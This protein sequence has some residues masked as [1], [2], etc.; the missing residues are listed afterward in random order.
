MKLHRRLYIFV[1]VVFASATL[2]AQ[3]P[4]QD[5]R[6]FKTVAAGAEYER[7][8]S[9]QKLWGFNRR[10]EWATPVRVPV[11]WLDSAYGRLEPY[12]VGG[13][14]E[15]KSLRLR[16]SNGKEYALRSI[17]KSRDE[18]IPPSLQKTFAEDIIRDGVSMSHPY[19]AFAIPHMLEKAG[20]CHTKP[21]LVY[22]PN[23]KA[24]D[25][26]DQKFGGDLYLLEQ[27]PE[28]DWS[29]ADH[30]GNFEEFDDTE[31]VI[32]SILKDHHHLADQ[33]T[34]AKA[35]LFDMLIADWDRHEG[36]WEW[37]KRQN[38][39]LS[40]YIPVPKDRDQAFY[41]HNGIIIDK[42]IPATGLSYMQH[43]DHRMGDPKALNY[44]QRYIDRFFTNELDRQDWITIAKSLQESLTSEVIEQ[45]VRGLPPEIFAVSGMELIEKLKSRIQQ[46]PAVAEAYYLFIADEV[47]VVG[48]T[49]NEFFDVNKNEKGQT[50]VAV[51][52]SNSSGQRETAPYYTRIFQ[53]G[54]TKEIRL[55]GIGGEDKYQ[56]NAHSPGITLRIIGGAGKDSIIQ[57]GKKVYI[58]DNKHNVFNVTSARLHISSDTAIHQHKYAWYSYDTKG[59]TPILSYNYEDR[60]HVGLQYQFKLHKWRREPF[61]TRQAI[62]V[63]YSITQK[64]FSAFYS[65]RYPNLIGKWDL[66]LHGEYDFI[67][68]TNFFGLGN[69]TRMDESKNI[70]FYR[71]HS[72]EW[73]VKTGLS[74]RKGKS[75]I[76]ISAFYYSVKIKQDSSL[77]VCEIFDQGKPGLF[78]ATNYSGIAADYRYVSVNDSIVPT[79]GM[80]FV[81]SATYANNFT[82]SEFFQKYQARVQT[83]LP[84]TG[85]FSLMIRVGGS[86][87]VAGDAVLNSAQAFQHAVIGGPENLRGYRFDRFWGKTAYYNN[88]ELRFITHIRTY[89]LNARLGI[90]GFFDN[91]RVWMPGE[92][93][94]RVH[95]SYGAG[96]LLAPFDFISLGLTYGITPESKLF[97]FRINTLL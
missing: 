64:A 49:K 97:Q 22:L 80:T 15:S 83:Y 38:G 70:K 5:D 20:I 29:E 58:Y 43:F 77:Y 12:K 8:K 46:L 37:G 51:Y 92:N 39:E 10:I 23:Q 59:F 19:G 53:P 78:A 47:E 45:S 90:T 76:D 81:A 36:N 67:R 85:K 18:V 26:F 93:S 86:T 13:G 55:Y 72:A 84:L 35:R 42:M 73:M 63:N 14:N 40:I 87:V 56:V 69:E 71:M 62:G 9:F 34:F 28:G 66:N 32:E 1:Q 7:P 6:R 88:N 17:N 24:L 65:A 16:N 89:L 68:W 96:L 31:K 61:A 75:T 94:N 27:R 4:Q 48:T 33:R 21:R 25:T 74:H 3:Q 2:Y 50:Q 79:K 60:I 82:Q 41:T 91:G 54:E 30:L 57:E 11:L 52:R 95:T 44:E